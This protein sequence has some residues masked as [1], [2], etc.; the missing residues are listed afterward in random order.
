MPPVVDT[1]DVVARRREVLQALSEP[2]TKPELVQRLSISRSTVDRAIEEL[3]SA[4]LVAREGSSYEATYAGRQ[5]L[6][7]YEGFLD[8]LDAL[9]RAQPVLDALPPDV[10]IDPAVL[11]DATVVESTIATP[12][13]PIEAATAL[14]D[15]ATK[16]RATGPSVT[17][18]Y[19]GEVAELVDDGDDTELVLT[20]DVFD[21]LSSA[22]EDAFARFSSADN[23]ALYVTDETMPYA[24]WIAE[25]PGG[26]VSG[27]I[28][29]TDEGVR[30]AVHSD[31]EAMNEWTRAKYEAFKR[32]ADRVD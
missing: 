14:G 2:L 21:A 8:R 31:T 15:G 17:P 25:K 12:Q 4:S 6:S 11:R 18:T 22:Y 27:F 20:A 24:V 5:A 16:L 13:A 9:T 1:A 26:T 30:G 10:D 3:R 29:H 19:I 28:V 32:D 7:A 23:V